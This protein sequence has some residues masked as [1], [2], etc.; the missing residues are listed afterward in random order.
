M[1]HFYRLLSASLLLALLGCQGPVFY[2]T[3]TYEVPSNAALWGEFSPGKLVRLKQDMFVDKDFKY[4]TT[5]DSDGIVQVGVGATE[6]LSMEKYKAN[7]KQWP[8][9]TVIEQGT[10][11]R[12]VKLEVVNQI[13]VTTYHVLLAELRSGEHAGKIVNI[14]PLL[15]SRAN[16]EG[17]TALHPNPKYLEIIEQ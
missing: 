9:Y 17:L 2:R 4:G 8:Q 3:R 12:C 1:N 15:H 7:P 13:S 5:I 11:L 6:R 14:S 10:V 16:P